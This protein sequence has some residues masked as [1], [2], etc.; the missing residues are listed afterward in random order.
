MT[1]GKRKIQVSKQQACKICEAQ[2][3][4]LV[5]TLVYKVTLI[6][7]VYNLNDTKSWKSIK[8]GKHLRMIP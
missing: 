4:T 1:T 6:V 2:I 3:S 8:V 7:I 5:N